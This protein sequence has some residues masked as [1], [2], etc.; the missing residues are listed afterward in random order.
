MI[1]TFKLFWLFK[2]LCKDE[3]ETIAVLVS[4]EDEKYAVRMKLKTGIVSDHIEERK[5]QDIAGVE[6]DIMSS[7]QHHWTLGLF[8]EKLPKFFGQSCSQQYKVWSMV[9]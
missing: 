7:I 1:T 5:V 2:N 4:T 6:E 9:D 3:N 8:T